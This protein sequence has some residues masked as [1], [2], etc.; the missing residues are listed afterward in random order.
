MSFFRARFDIAPVFRPD[1]DIAM[2]IGLDVQGDQ[3]NAHL[4]DGVG[5]GFDLS[6]VV[7]VRE[8]GGGV[9]GI[10]EGRTPPTAL[11][12]LEGGSVP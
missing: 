12:V 2:I 10:K 3:G 8:T 9:I 1:D 7:G 5:V 4:V 6:Q 11:F